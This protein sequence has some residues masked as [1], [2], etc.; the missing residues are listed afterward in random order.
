MIR[1]AAVL[2]RSEVAILA[3][4]QGPKI[5]IGALEGP[6]FRLS[7][8]AEWRLDT[9]QRP[10][11]PRRA[12]VS[13]PDL[14]GAARPG[15]PVLLG[16]G[17]VELEAVRIDGTDLVLRV[18]HGGIVAPHAGVFLP[19]ARLRSA[20]LGPKDLSDLALALEEGTDFVALSFV[21]DAS[22]VRSARRL[23]ERAGARRVGIVAKIERA[24][25]LRHIDGIL[26]EADALM[27]ARGDLGIEV[28]LER[29]AL[30]QKHLVHLAN[31]AGRPVIVATQM[32]LSMVHAP[33]PTRAETTDA[34][35]AVLDGADALMLSEETAIGDYPFEAVRWLDRICRTTEAAAAGS[36]VSIHV[37]PKAGK[38]VDRSVAD[39]AFDLATALSA[40]AIVVPTDSGRTARL[41]AAH[42]PRVP[43][44]A[45]SAHPGTRRQLSLV[46]GVEAVECPDHL[47]LLELRA[48]AKQIVA[49]HPRVGPEGPIVV[50]AGF[51]VEGV[52]T[53]LVTVV[54]PEETRPGPG[55]HRSPSGSGRPAEGG[56]RSAPHPRAGPVPRRSR[57]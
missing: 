29:L 55:K 56:A 28:P 52:P 3:D 54:D 32:L 33:R 8:G 17:N 12:S 44:I 19:N 45:L 40:T 20:N 24:E 30:E 15:D 37:A 25:A 38:G 16:D 42:R 23:I 35:N 46:W 2:R 36:E 1:S 41:V 4:L 57:S 13:L 26:E 7:D 11:N 34:A 5:R 10:G 21:R 6:P 22:D 49:Q 50:T 48:L 43:V 53:N 9:S 31:A 14:R 18:V 27:V 39:T 47:N 51:P